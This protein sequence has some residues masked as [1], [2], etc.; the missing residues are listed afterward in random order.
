MEV[1][2]S[3]SRAGE[4]VLAQRGEGSAWAFPAPLQEVLP[5]AAAAV[6]AERKGEMEGRQPRAPP[7]QRLESGWVSPP[8]SWRAHRL[9]EHQRG[10]VGGDADHQRR[11]AVDHGL[12][13]AKPEKA[14]LSTMGDRHAFR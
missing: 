12:A 6:M 2:R 14:G 1:P 7:A 3:A 9:A 11:K 5:A 8:R 13:K 10:A 4:Q